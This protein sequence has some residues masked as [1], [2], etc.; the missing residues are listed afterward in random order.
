MSM[1]KVLKVKKLRTI[2]EET[3]EGED[4]YTVLELESVND[5]DHNQRLKISKDESKGFVP[6][7]VVKLHVVNPQQTLE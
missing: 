3:G 2:T 6:G 5:G 7:S 1:E 4:T